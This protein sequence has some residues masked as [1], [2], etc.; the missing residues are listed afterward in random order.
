[1]CTTKMLLALFLQIQLQSVASLTIY[2]SSKP[3]ENDKDLVGLKYLNEP[4]QVLVTKNGFSTCFRFNYRRFDTH[5]FYFGQ[6]KDSSLQFDIS[7]SDSFEDFSI[8]HLGTLAYYNKKQLIFGY[9]WY[10]TF[11]ESLPSVNVWNHLCVSFGPRYSNFTLV[12]VMY[13]NQII[14]NITHKNY[15]INYIF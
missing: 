6:A 13:H 14:Q 11:N 8:A 10:A 9:P 5:L 4:K 2:T 3:I 1:M 12:L 15:N 7:L